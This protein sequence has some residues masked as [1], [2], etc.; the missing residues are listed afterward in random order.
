MSIV[1]NLTEVERQNR[2]RDVGHQAKVYAARIRLQNAVDQT[3][4]LDAI[5]EIAGNL[6]GCEQVAVFTVDKKHSALWLHWSFG[7]DPNK[8]PILE[9]EHEPRLRPVLQ[10][11]PSFRLRLVNQN[12]LSTDDP[13]N[14]LV[15][16]MVNGDVCAVVVLFRLFAHKPELEAVDLEI[17]EVMSNFAGR[18]VEPYRSC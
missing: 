8:H 10:G 2:L 15:P 13:V 9:V 7:I 3:D 5:R 12:L 6:I 16:I 11:T 17:C 1:S 4:A 18:A 14:A